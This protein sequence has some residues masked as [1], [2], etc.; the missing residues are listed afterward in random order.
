MAD[1]EVAA[2][3][4]EVHRHKFEVYVSKYFLYEM[5]GVSVITSTA[6]RA[7]FMQRLITMYTYQTYPHEDMEWIIMDD[8]E[9]SVESFFKDLCLPNIRY[10]R[11]DTRQPMGTKLNRLVYEARGDIL[12]VMDDDDYYPPE[13]VASAVAAFARNPWCEVAGTSLVYM[14]STA[15]G[16]VYQAGPYHNKHALNC[17]L[18][19][20]RSYS[21]KQLFDPAE[22]C[23]VERRFLKGFTVPMIQLKPSETIL[24][25]IHSSN[26]FDKTKTSQMKLTDLRLEDFITYSDLHAAFANST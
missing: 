23:A 9:E 25:V 4:V 17:T 13:R 1:L 21:Q 11:S 20:K 18:A 22:V 24:H 8:G 10:I 19:W 6:N 2:G 5:V 7:R 15:T 14:Y 16:E 12:V 26:T 3:A